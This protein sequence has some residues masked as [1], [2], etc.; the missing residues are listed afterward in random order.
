MY[1]SRVWLNEQGKSST[2]SIVAYE[3]KSD[4]SE[5]IALFFEIADCHGKVRIHKTD[6]DSVVDFCQKLMILA[7]EANQFADYLR[8]QVNV[9][10]PTNEMLKD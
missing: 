1:N 7:D 9:K 2:G 5:E 4:W 3:G 10:E 8:N 6:K